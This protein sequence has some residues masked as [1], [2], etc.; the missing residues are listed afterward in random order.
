MILTG[1][2]T[3]IDDVLITAELS[4]PKMRRIIINVLTF[5][6]V[7]I[8]QESPGVSERDEALAGHVSLCTKRAEGQ[9]AT[10]GCGEKGKG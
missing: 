1:I 10:H 4:M 7:I 8:M 3:G 9:S 5:L 2:I 6:T